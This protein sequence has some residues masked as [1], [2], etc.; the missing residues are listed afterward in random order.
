V[1][2]G[3]LPP[4]VCCR[5]LA[6]ASAPSSTTT[7][8]CACRGPAGTWSRC[9]CCCCCCDCCCWQRVWVCPW[10]AD[11]AVTP[12]AGPA[13]CPRFMEGRILLRYLQLAAAAAHVQVCCAVA[14]VTHAYDGRGTTKVTRDS[15]VDGWPLVG[16]LT[17]VSCACSRSQMWQFTLIPCVTKRASQGTCICR[18]HS[19]LTGDAHALYQLLHTPNRRCDRSRS[20]TCKL[21]HQPVFAPGTPKPNFKSITKTVLEQLSTTCV[22]ATQAQQRCHPNPLASTAVQKAC[23]QGHKHR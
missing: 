5:L 12:Q 2:V 1:P 21:L 6:F 20:C 22:R 10:S 23:G 18:M 16:V 7:P 14:L 8:C 11:A 19:D 4:V 17:V 13:C 3:T 9:R 15:L